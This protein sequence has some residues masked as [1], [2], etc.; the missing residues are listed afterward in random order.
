MMQHELAQSLSQIQSILTDLMSRYILKPVEIHFT[1]SL[2]NELDLLQK[3]LELYDI[4]LRYHNSPPN[5]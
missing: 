2:Q 3:Q 5:Q 4:E 1:T